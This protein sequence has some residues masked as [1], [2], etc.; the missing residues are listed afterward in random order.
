MEIKK[1]TPQNQED[2]A[3]IYET[4]EKMIRKIAVS[5]L[6]D[7]AL[8]E[9]CLH[10]VIL[11]LTVVLN[12]IGDVGSAEAKAFITV[13]TRNLAIDMKKKKSRELCIPQNSKEAYVFEEK[14]YDTYF[15]DENGF[16]EEMRC[17]MNGLRK[18]EKEALVLRYTYGL[19]YAEIAKLLGDKRGAIEQRVCRARK[20]LGKM[21][22]ADY[23][24]NN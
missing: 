17:Y 3:R 1:M 4:Y 18:E 6:H 22:M 21:I 20:K 15:V 7:G 14:V 10:E 11:R 9:D 8:S 19:P 16:S 12:R 13:I 24:S 5:I 2:V 23:N